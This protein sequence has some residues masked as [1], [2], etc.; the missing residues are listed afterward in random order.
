MSDIIRNSEG[1]GIKV[2]DVL[3]KYGSIEDC[4]DENQYAKKYEERIGNLI[5]DKTIWFSKYDNLND[6]YEVTV[7]HYDYPDTQAK[8][9]AMVRDY[10]NRFMVEI[11]SLTDSEKNL[12]MWS[13]YA[14]SH[15]GYCLEFE[16][17]N[18]ENIFKVSYV[19][20]IPQGIN[21]ALMHLAP[22]DTV[23]REN[24]CKTF[25]NKSNAWAHEN[26]YRIICVDNAGKNSTG[27]KIELVRTGLR[28]K[29][30]I[31]GA[32]CGKRLIKMIKNDSRI[33]IPCDQATICPGEYKIEVKKHIKK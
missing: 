31:L 26:E 24:L 1:C 8:N 7:A 23:G 33:T 9:A 29:R 6:P 28:L 25:T 18:P 5:G 10:A 2:G 4:K 12:L 11:L 27:E 20:K 3:Y 15:K 17:V 13:Y 21:Y 14:N 30:I 16:V 32:N 22:N 19:D